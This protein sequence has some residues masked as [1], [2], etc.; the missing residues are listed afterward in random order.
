MLYTLSRRVAATCLRAAAKAAQQNN[1][2]LLAD[3]VSP[4]AQL[5]YCEVIRRGRDDGTLELTLEELEGRSANA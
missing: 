5:A 2:F 1:R 4:A 3:Q